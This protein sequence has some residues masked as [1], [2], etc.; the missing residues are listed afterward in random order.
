MKIGKKVVPLFNILTLLDQNI[1]I[2]KFQ[3]QK[4]REGRK[5]L[6]PKQQR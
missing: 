2:D 1:I 3:Q 4:K 5:V 6:C